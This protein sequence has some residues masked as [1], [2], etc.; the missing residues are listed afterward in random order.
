VVKAAEQ[1]DVVRA[2]NL[3]QRAVS[4]DSSFHSVMKPRVDDPAL[5]WL[6]YVW[7]KFSFSF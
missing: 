7:G 1:N 5:Q 6:E 3:T 2:T 4:L